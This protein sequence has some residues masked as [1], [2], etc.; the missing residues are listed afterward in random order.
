MSAPRVRV[1]IVSWNTAELLGRC[2]A[3]LPAALAGVDA[4]VVVVDNAS[5]DESVEVAKA[6]P[7][8]KVVANADNTGYANAMNVALA[9]TP[10]EA[11]ADVLIALNPD[12]EPGPGSLAELVRRLWSDPTLGLVVPRL[13]GT[14]G[15]AGTAAQ[16]QHSVYRFP[17]PTLTAVVSLTPGRLQRGRIGRRWWLEGAHPHD[18]PSDVDWAIGAV[19][20]LRAAACRAVAAGPA[21]EPPGSGPATAGPAPYSERWFMYVEDLDLCWRLARGG[22]RVRL[23]ADIE[24]PHVGNAAGAQAWGGGR[25]RRWVEAT[26]DWYGRV[27]GM[28]AARIWAFTNLLGAGLHALSLYVRAQLGPRRAESRAIARELRAVVGAH[29]QAVV[30][31]PPPPDKTPPDKT[32][33][34]KTPPGHRSR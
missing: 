4:E 3:A 2:L 30:W 15:R 12:T 16:L 10:G 24:V 22:W 19:H 9:D 18:T 21:Y 23:E 1:G 14:P 34:G 5:V 29:A 33:P 25:T 11:T 28:G 27:K 26:Y 20:V 32:P 13:V 6:V 17:S 8:V 7:G 31:G